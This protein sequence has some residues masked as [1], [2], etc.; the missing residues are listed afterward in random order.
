MVQAK[1]IPKKRDTAY[2]LGDLFGTRQRADLSRSITPW[3]KHHFIMEE[4]ERVRRIRLACG[5]SQKFVAAEVGISASSL[6]N[7]E[8]SKSNLMYRV[9][10]RL[11]RVLNCD[12]GAFD[13]GFGGP[14]RHVVPPL[15]RK[16]PADPPKRGKGKKTG[17]QA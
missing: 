13:D 14:L 16:R 6:S 17:P 4:G 8:G 1:G 2:V 9:A 10:M 7:I 12:P 3:R 15:V 11:A 5:L